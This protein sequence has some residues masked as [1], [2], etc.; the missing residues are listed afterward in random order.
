MALSAFSRPNQILSA[1]ASG[2]LLLWEGRNCVQ[3]RVCVR[4]CVRMH[5]PY[6][7][8]YKPS[9][10]QVHKA[11][12]GLITTL[13][14]H[15]GTST[16]LS[17]GKDKRVRLWSAELAPLC[18]IDTLLLNSLEPIVTGLD[19]SSDGKRVLLGTRGGEVRVPACVCA[20]VYVR[21]C[22][23]VCVPVCTCVCV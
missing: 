16:L 3:V 11:H 21:V 14:F 18:V 2:L 17:S 7:R 15:R 19:L 12:E 1:T 13:T 20:C 8:E 22:V 4:A 9:H 10:A 23:C 6:V 5:F